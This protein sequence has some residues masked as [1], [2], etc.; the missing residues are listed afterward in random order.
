MVGRLFPACKAASTS[1]WPRHLHCC[2]L[3]HPRPDAHAIWAF[4]LLNRVPLSPFLVSL[5]CN[6]CLFFS[7]IVESSG[8]CSVHRLLA[9][10]AHRVS[11]Q[12][13]TACRLTPARR[14]WP[15]T[16]VYNSYTSCQDIFI[17]EATIWRRRQNLRTFSCRE[18]SLAPGSRISGRTSGR[19]AHRPLRGRVQT[20]VPGG[21]RFAEAIGES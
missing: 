15:P 19:F 13:L 11:P 3:D 20:P 8:L 7:D 5:F 6:N 1:K 9:I 10:T 17:Q 12:A 14:H 4:H 18:G 2:G 21:L 16:L